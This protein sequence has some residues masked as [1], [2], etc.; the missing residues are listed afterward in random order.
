MTSTLPILWVAS[1]PPA[2]GGLFPT[3]ELIGC[4]SR[5]V[6][7]PDEALEW[8][9]RFGALA[10][11]LSFPLEGWTPAGLV[12]EF[13][14]VNPRI[15]VLVY[16]PEGTPE[17]AFRLGGLG[18]FAFLS[19]PLDRAALDLR[20]EA[21]VEA[22]RSRGLEGLGRSVSGAPWTGLLVGR[23]HAIGNVLEVIR[24][25]GSRRCTVLI[26]GE[27]GTGKEM[28]A[29][30]L[31]Q[32]GPRAARPMVTV[33]CGALP[34]HLLEAELFGHVKGAFTGAINQRVGRFEQ[35]HGSTLFLDEIGDMPLELQVKL[36]RVLQEREFQRLGSSE[37][38]RVD[39]RVVAASNNDL[40][41]KV[42]QGK[43]REDLFYRLNVVPIAMPAL[44][45]RPEDIPPLVEHFVAGFCRQEALPKKR[46][47]P[48]A[49]DRLRRHSWPGNVR[50]LEN[51]IEMAV[52][53]SGERQTLHPADFPLP[54]AGARKPARTA[55]HPAVVLPDE[56]LDYDEIVGA[57]ERNILEQ[58]LHKSGGNKKRAADLLRLKRTTLSAKL[59]SLE[60]R[61]A[62][63]S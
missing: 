19:G 34:E 61:T 21:A 40:A 13:H 14:R 62:C 59:R 41:A 6:R 35:A 52:V 45:E 11:V 9:Q 46:V 51:A 22:S 4:S 44:R 8:V 43:F 38:L 7:D 56:G 31:H 63:A 57:F 32:A 42:R 20:L 3:N 39:I 25:V 58:A 10:V 1:G 55:A 5:V 36:L 60:A 29:R 23:S 33:N 30:A 18:A 54:G 24:L 26:T 49:L 37:T 12:E 28:A 15:P 53:L 27:T 2:A 16:D 47:H 17:D 50:E 48:E